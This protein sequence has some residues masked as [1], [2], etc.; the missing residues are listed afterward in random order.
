MQIGI[1]SGRPVWHEDGVVFEVQG[2]EGFDAR[3]GLASLLGG[4]GGLSRGEAIAGSVEW[5]APFPMPTQLFAIGLNYRHH[6][7]EM[8]LAIPTSPM[9]FTKFPSSIGA[10]NC[11]VR[12]P[13][14]TTDWEAELVVVM[15]RGGRNFS[16][17]EALSCVAGYMVGQDFSER[18]V[19][20]A[21]SP[22][23][24]SLGKS[25]EN[26]APMGPWLTTSDSIGDPQNLRIECRVNG[27]VMQSESTSDMAYS[28]AEIVSHIS[29]V[30]EVRPGDLIFTGSPAGVGQGLKPPRF[31]Q[32]GDIVETSIS[33]LGAIS[34]RMKG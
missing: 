10:P 13:G 19:Q 21:N 5:E 7:H 23:Q 27:D 31:L 33:G 26:F 14:G 3:L 25:Y 12:I 6:A 8:G 2:A 11:D 15:G 32:P 24:F 9:V 1:A 18:T 30:V 4:L 16:A 20:M 34:N 28:V 29:Q 17:A 22:A